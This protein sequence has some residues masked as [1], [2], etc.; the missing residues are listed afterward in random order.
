MHVAGAD[1]GQNAEP[2]VLQ[3]IDHSCPRLIEPAP[4]RCA[5]YPK[6]GLLVWKEAWPFPFDLVVDYSTVQH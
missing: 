1:P 4:G 5:V 6:M 3:R 2:F